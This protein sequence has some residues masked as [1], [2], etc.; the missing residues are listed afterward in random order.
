M[1]M[2]V[3]REEPA[4]EYNGLAE[5]LRPA[6]TNPLLRDNPLPVPSSAI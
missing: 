2:M 3:G 4:A 5:G 6:R 1:K